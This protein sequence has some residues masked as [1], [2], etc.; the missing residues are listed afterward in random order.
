MTLGVAAWGWLSE[1][2]PVH[3]EPETEE[4]SGA[5][6]VLDR[7]ARSTPGCS[8]CSGAC[9]QARAAGSLGKERVAVALRARQV[10]ES[11][12]CGLH[13]KYLGAIRGRRAVA[14]SNF[15]LPSRV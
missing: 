4:G 11:L 3:L 6:V 9:K 10:M 14:G 2:T 15:P 8:V 5:A 12:V 13:S 7:T 1:E